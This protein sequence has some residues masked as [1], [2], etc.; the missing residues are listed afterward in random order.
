MSI[1]SCNNTIV[2]SLFQCF[3]FVFGARA[4]FMD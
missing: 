2:S 4:L 1:A 3:F